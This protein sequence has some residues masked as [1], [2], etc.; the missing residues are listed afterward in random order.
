MNYAVI[1]GGFSGLLSAYLLEKKG[2][3]VTLYEKEHRIGGHCETINNK[4]TLAEIG[5][6]F[7]FNS[8]IKELFIDLDIEYNQRFTHRNFVDSKFQKSEHISNA[9]INEAI[10]DLFI[11]ENILK[12]DFT[13]VSSDNYAYIDKEMMQPFY[14]FL[15]KN[16]LKHIISLIE[17][18]LSSFG[19]GSIYEIP[20]YYA[21]NVF[22]IKTISS[23]IK[24]EKLLFAKNGMSEV[25]NKLS[26]KIKDIRYNSYIVNIEKIN[27]KIKLET[28]YGVDYYDKVIIT[29]KLDDGVIKNEVYNNF[30]NKISFNPY[31]ISA[32]E[33]ENKKIVTTYYKNNFGKKGKI[34]FFHTFK[35]SSSNILVAYTYGYLNSDSIKQINEDLKNTG[36]KIKRLITTKQWEIFPHIKSE[37]LSENVY[38]DILKIQEEEKIYI[39]GSIA[40][41]PSISHL[42]ESIRNFILNLN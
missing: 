32:Y 15:I 10:K 28:D 16:N 40:S 21:L 22:D 13:D 34:Q 42:Y 12:R 33:V 7:S 5:T 8:Y 11:L 37:S 2:F 9:S 1:G 14:D 6:V 31:F 18:L 17:P 23:F 19:F 25:I 36:I 29:T 35:D 24:G 39:I 3:K 20:T 4:D 41:K 27:N 38:L 30:M 26:Q